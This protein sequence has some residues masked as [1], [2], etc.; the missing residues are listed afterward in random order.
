M[1]VSHADDVQQT[2][3]TIA[4][5]THQNMTPNV[6]RQNCTAVVVM[7]TAE[8]IE[9]IPHVTQRSQCITCIIL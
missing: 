8:P 1:L 6:G 4:H 3:K 7:A 9:C 5:A 2:T